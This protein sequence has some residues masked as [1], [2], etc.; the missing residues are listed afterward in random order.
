MISLQSL[1]IYLFSDLLMIFAFVTVFLKTLTLKDNGKL[2]L[3]ILSS[4]SISSSIIYYVITGNYS[5]FISFVYVIAM[6][7]ILFKERFHLKLLMLL[8]NFIIQFM[9]EVTTLVILSILRNSPYEDYFSIHNDLFNLLTIS[10]FSILVLVFL[11]LIKRGIIPNHIPMNNLKKGHIVILA[12]L[13]SFVL[14]YSAVID[15]LLDIN[16]RITLNLPTAFLLLTLFMVIAFVIGVINYINKIYTNQQL[17]SKNIFITQQLE[18]QLRHYQQLE[19][20]IRETRKV[21]HDMN[22]HFLCLSHLVEENQIMKLKDYLN[23][24]KVA[25][26]AI[27]TSI[28]TGNSMIDAIINEKL[29]YYKSENI[30]FSFQGSF[31]GTENIKPMDLCTIIANSLDNA[32]EANVQLPYPT[33]RFVNMSCHIKQ[34]HMLYKLINACQ[35][36]E[37]DEINLLETTKIDKE[38]HGFGLGNIKEAVAQNRGDCKY[39][40]E[41]RQFVLE[42]VIPLSE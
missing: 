4:L 8:M 26:D 14:F 30:S 6:C 34:S 40:I 19:V 2:Y 20:S 10:L 16:A 5:D 12:S 22:N 25:I 32:F 37:I 13:I 42:I 29:A 28:D 24:M 1:L 31:R 41:D 38:Q 9:I 15:I 18:Y 23:A 35:L 21:K 11:L 39:Y 7:F 33:P 17:E 3:I 27:E 36:F